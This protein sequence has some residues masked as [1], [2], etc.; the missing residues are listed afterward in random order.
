[1]PMQEV[2]ALLDDCQCP[3]LHDLTGKH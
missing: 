1:L 2:I 3:L